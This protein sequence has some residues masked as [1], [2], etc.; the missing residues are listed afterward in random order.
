M[1]IATLTLFIIIAIAL[2]ILIYL[3]SGEVKSVGNALIGTS[4]IELFENK[5]YRGVQR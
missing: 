3:Q 1:G 2:I 5:K 4:D